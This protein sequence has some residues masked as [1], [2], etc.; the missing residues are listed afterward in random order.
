[1]RLVQLTGFVLTCP[2]LLTTAAAFF[3]P[4]HTYSHFGP[5]QERDAALKAGADGICYTYTVQAHDTCATLA[6]QYGITEQQITDYNAGSW[7]WTGCTGVKQG[8]F[9]CLSSGEFPMPVALPQATCGP[10][11]PG[12]T[13]PGKYSD[14]A[15]LNPCPSGDCVSVNSHPL[16]IYAH[17]NFN[18]LQ[19]SMSGQ[20]GTTSDFCVSPNC[21]SN[22]GQKDT[23]NPN[24]VKPTT[25]AAAVPAVTSTKTSTTKS[26]SSTT[27]EKETVTHKQTV[28]KTEKAPAKTTE[29]AAP[30]ETWQIAIYNGKD[31]SGDYY[32][33]EGHNHY[34]TGCLDLAG[35]I[36]TTVTD[37]G[38]SCRWWT[39]GGLKWTKC[40]DGKLTKPKSWY[41]TSGECVVYSD[42]K[43]SVESGRAY[44]AWLGCQNPNAHLW[45]PS[46]FGSLE[47]SFL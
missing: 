32:L 26:T 20:C 44:G 21:I 39:D 23:N 9:I 42:R 31:C 36:S 10:Q 8:D 17:T 1:M 24:T 7:G 35:D 33:L 47:C 13:R 14:L 30:T 43:C 16:W 41:V 19:C 29:A 6:Q 12:T 46:V 25:T 27:S 4:N 40:S 2:I 45:E 22:C 38:T 37:S 11:V 28:T 3:K 15:S 34:V 18:V 5:I